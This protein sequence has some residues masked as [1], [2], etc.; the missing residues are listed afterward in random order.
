M[1]SSTLLQDTLAS[2]AQL[3]DTTLDKPP[4]ANVRNDYSSLQRVAA[5]LDPN[6]QSS[7]SELAA[8]S[9]KDTLSLT[10]PKQATLPATLALNREATQRAVRQLASLQLDDR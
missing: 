1:I 4:S 8:V 2:V 6:L 7:S 5:D 3:A 9:L 10:G